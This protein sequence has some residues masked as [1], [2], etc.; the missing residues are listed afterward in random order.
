L[1][2]EAFLKAVKMANASQFDREVIVPYGENLHFTFM[3]FNMSYL[4]NITFTVDGYL[5]ASE[6]NN[7]WPNDIYGGGTLDFIKIEDSENIHLRGSGTIDGHGY[8]WWM[9]EYIQTNHHG[10]PHLIKMNRIKNCT[11]EGLK[12]FN[13]PM[14]HMS[15]N[16]IDGFLIQDI[17]IRVDI[18]E[19]KNLAIKHG[20]YDYRLN[21]PTFPL[22]TDG[23]DPSGKNV[24][25]R[26]SK[27][28]SYDDSIAVKPSKNDTK[29]A[30][31]SEN[32]LAYNLTTWMGVGMTIGSV[33]PNDGYNCVRNVTFRDIKLYSPI[34]SIYVKTNPGDHGS[35]IIENILYENIEII[36]PIWWNIYIGP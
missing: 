33:P 36:M 17:E 29:L 25:I 2:A 20:K 19:Q 8:W 4:N 18:F 1:N 5:H 24:I 11:I 34:K 3:P 31:C 27:I 22:N 26:N 32:I 13:S 16:D 28:L 21:L 6:D 30:T 35:G 14:F 10:R 12:F 9:R 23:I 7:N 15:L